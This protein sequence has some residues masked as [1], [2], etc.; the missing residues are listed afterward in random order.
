MTALEEPC[1]R[2]VALRHQT[3]LGALQGYQ[4]LFGWGS[5][6]PAFASQCYDHDWACQE[7]CNLS[8][9]SDIIHTLVHGS[10]VLLH[11]HLPR[12]AAAKTSPGTS[13]YV[14][15][16]SPHTLPSRKK[17]WCEYYGNVRLTPAYEVVSPSQR[18]TCIPWEV[19][20]RRLHHHPEQ[21]HRQEATCHQSSFQDGEP[22]LC[23]CPWVEGVSVYPFLWRCLSLGT[24][25]HL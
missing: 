21:A 7:P 12:T 17:R 14:D 15:T 13:G 24:S 23:T 5:I 19:H 2:G 11:N 10:L 9:E 1:Y 22:P 6:P 18:S 25:P 4:A 8:A 16:P 20:T 3:V